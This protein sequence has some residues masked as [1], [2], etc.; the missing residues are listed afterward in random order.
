VSARNNAAI[1]AHLCDIVPEY[2][3]SK[4]WRIVLGSKSKVAAVGA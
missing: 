2:E 3:P 4:E 1:L